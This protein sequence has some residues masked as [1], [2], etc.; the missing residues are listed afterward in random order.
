MHFV[1]HWLNLNSKYYLTHLWNVLLCNVNLN[2]VHICNDHP[3][4]VHIWDVHFCDVHFAPCCFFLCFAVALIY[5]LMFKS[6]LLQLSVL[7]F[8]AC[9]C[10]LLCTQWNPVPNCANFEAVCYVMSAQNCMCFVEQKL[11]YT[12]SAPLA[13]YYSVERYIVNWTNTC[14]DLKKY[15]SHFWQIFS[16]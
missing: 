2:N 1:P 6:P 3:H 8:T 9:C 11:C 12:L 4:N 14:S 15:I 5:L 10:V 13:Q 7:C 16:R